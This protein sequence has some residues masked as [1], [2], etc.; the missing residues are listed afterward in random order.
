MYDFVADLFPLCRSI[1]GNGVRETLRRVAKH[2]PLDVHEVPTG[3]QVFDWTVPREWNIRGGRVTG[4]DGRTVVDFASSNLHVVG[5]STPVHA[6]LTRAELETHLHS[7]PEHPDWVPYRTS[8]YSEDWGFCL[9]QQQRDE[10]DD[11]DYDVFIDAD[12]DDGHLTYGECLIPGETNDEVLISCHV[13]HPSLAN[14]NLS[15][16]AAATFLAE[17]LGSTANRYSYRFLFIPGTIGSVTWLALNEAGV[18]RI[19]HG[20]V[21]ACLGNS[22]PFTYKRSRRGD[23][24]V[25]GAVAHVLD[26]W[27]GEHRV[28][29]FTPWGYDERQF[30]S[31]GFDLPVGGLTR[32]PQGGF[33]EYHTSADNLDLVRPEKLEESLALLRSILEV[34]ERDSRFENCNPMCEPRLGARGLYPSVGGQ[35]A[36]VDQ[37]ALLWV[38]NLSDGRHSLLEIAERAHLPFAT[39][40]EAAEALQRVDLLRA[41]S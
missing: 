6:R 35:G 1:T 19:K 2:V 32:A 14:D 28:V 11:G 25:D 41:L 31:P 8:Y 26:H 7:V 5:Y 22:A 24:A 39:I 33:P 29:D 15:G 27:P 3:T 21:L 20:L 18:H 30:C 12:L 9:T 4:P 40:R 36:S 13:C 16:I 17:Q 38:L 10:L 37:L 23:A 34:L